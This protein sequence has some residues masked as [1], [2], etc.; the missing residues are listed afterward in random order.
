MSTTG[1][2]PSVE[3]RCG[4]VP[5]YFG[6]PASKTHS[7]T[8]QRL[9]RLTIESMGYE[10]E[11]FCT[12]A[13]DDGAAPQERLVTVPRLLAERLTQAVHRQQLFAKDYNCFA[14]SRDMA[15]LRPADRL[16]AYHPTDFDPPVDTYEGLP[17]ARALKLG[18]IGI[19][20]LRKLGA[21]HAMVGLDRESREVMQVP[22]RGGD[23]GFVHSDTVVNFYDWVWPGMGSRL[24]LGG[25]T[26]L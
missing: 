26:N 20:G 12:D 5:D 25:E 7:Y 22:C 14:F 8:Y 9:V 10:R 24:Y 13:Q 4:V 1:S 6:N 11:L 15:G 21:W 23:I 16:D 2:E 19:V 17:R 3:M 18:Q